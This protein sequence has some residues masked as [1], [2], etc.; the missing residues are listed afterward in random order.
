MSK[1]SNERILPDGTF[2]CESCHSRSKLSTLPKKSGSYKITCYKCKHQTLV[3]IEEDN[4]EEKIIEEKP[5]FTSYKIEIPPS[6]DEKKEEVQYNEIQLPSTKFFT[7]EEAV[8]KPF[9]EITKVTKK[10]SDTIYEK[11][12]FFRNLFPKSFIEFFKSKGMILIGIVFLILSLGLFFF[13]RSEYS[14]VKL[15]TEKLLL[16]L[17]KHKPSKILDRNGNLVSEIFQKKTGTMKLTEMPEKLKK[18]ILAVEDKNFYSHSGIDYLAFLRASYKNLI[19]LK[20]IQ[21]ASTITQQLARILMNDRRKSLSRKFKEALV[22]IALEEK[23]SKEQILEAYLNQVYLGHG[24]FGIE[25]A[26][27]YYFDKDPSELKVMEIILISSLASAPNKYSPFKNRDLSENR[28]K[29][30]IATLEGKG[31]IKEKYSGKVFKFYEKLKSPEA[32]TVFGRRYDKA[33]FVTEHI[34]EL[35]KSIDSS[36][37]IY[38]LGGYTIETTLIKEAQEFL[39]EE[40]KNHITNLKEKKK[41]KRI[42]I[43]KTAEKDS[44]SKE[45]QAA[46]IGLEPN[47]GAVLFMHGGGEEFNSN[48]QFNR[49]IQMKRQTGSSIKPILYSAA[50]DT[51]KFNAASVLIDSP[52]QFV[53]ADG[54][55]GWSPDNFGNSYEGEM[56]IREALAKSKNTIA[57]QV[58]ERLGLSVLEKYYSNYF[59]PDQAEKQKRYRNDLSV[60]L[61]SLEISP[62]EMTSAFSAFANDGV[63][64]RPYL[65]KRILDQNGKEI[66]NSENSDEFQLKVPKQR[67]VISPE[68]AEVMVSLMRGSANSSGLKKYGKVGDVA[69]KTGTTN[70]YIDA[71][72]VGT[73]ANL[74]MAVWIGYDDSSYSMGKSGMGAEFSAPLWAKIVSRLKSDEILQETKFQFSKHATRLAVCRSTGNIAKNCDCS[75]KYAEYFTKEGRPSNECILTDFEPKLR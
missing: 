72:F 71:W 8:S 29:Q 67:K 11:T 60:T 57:V 53:S 16:Q 39:A 18:I 73:K 21:G 49:A 34:R 27:K 3:K 48:N 9:I 54:R 50:I 24:A 43:K 40:I 59:F 41:I 45:L 61:G 14:E 10:L 20:Y 75:D 35:L 12:A 17:N 65:V 36:I 58:G 56:T 74:A 33:P 66:F 55:G 69:G 26:A 46:V 19:N 52:I 63:I 37:D 2:I 25:N 4:Y 70:D 13:I 51:G 15:E 28:V 32:Q 44:V 1:L 64:R 68:T 62:L 42:R 47:T 38:D 7:V 5:N 30:I 31:I 6:L 23:L 22:A